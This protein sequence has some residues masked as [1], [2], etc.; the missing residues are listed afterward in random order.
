MNQR[1]QPNC[2][3]CGQ[4]HLLPVTETRVF[5]P[6]GQRVEV[7]L[8]TSCCDACGADAIRP[9]QHLE[10]LNRLKARKPH[11]G[12]RLMG[13]EIVALRKRHGLTLRTASRLFGTSPSAFARYDHETA[14]PDDRTTLRLRLAIDSPASLAQLAEEA[15]LDLPRLL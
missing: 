2:P 14:Y 12:T 15:G 7:E 11:Y 4:G 3:A 9:A 13:E 5:M 1:R 8:L 6:N 10:N